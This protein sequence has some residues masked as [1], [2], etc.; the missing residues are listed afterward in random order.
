MKFR[1]PKDKIVWSLLLVSLVLYL[2]DY[3]AFG[4][5]GE[6]GFGFMS[7]VAFLPVYVLFV[8]LMLERVIKNREREA[9][10]KKLNMV[11]GIFFS[12]VGTQLLRDFLDFFPDGHQ[13]SLH[14]RPTPQW[15]DQNFQEA[16]QFLKAQDIRL[17]SRRGD[18]ARLKDFLLEKKGTMLALMENPN[19]LE[20]DAFTD[21]LWAVFHLIEELQA[22]RSLVGLPES[23][24]DHLSGDMKRAH[25]HLLVQWVSYMWHLKRD[26]PYLYSLAVRTNPMN[27]EAHAEVY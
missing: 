10:M 27:P 2:A 15:K 3:Y 26:Y 24:L 9:M 12:E 18:L 13:I 21:L 17:D 25:T 23:D 7:N 4:R 22:R 16:L 11:I 6:I 14:L 5:L 8:T 1:I 20:H 19:L